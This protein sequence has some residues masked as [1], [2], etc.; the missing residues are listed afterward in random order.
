MYVAAGEEDVRYARNQEKTR[1]WKV[2]IPGKWVL[3]VGK[4]ISLEE[5]EKAKAREIPYE[6]FE[7]WN[8]DE[9]QSG[10]I[11]RGDLKCLW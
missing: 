5:L 6:E 4:D 2:P 7:K 10:C 8:H 9:C 1:A 3:I 11:R